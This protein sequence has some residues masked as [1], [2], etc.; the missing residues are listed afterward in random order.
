MPKRILSES[1]RHRTEYLR[2][3]HDE[4]GQVAVR[5]TY[6]DDEALEKNKRARLEGKVKTGNRF[7][8]HEGAE[9]IYAFSIPSSKAWVDFQAS[10]PGIVQRLRS[11]DQIIREKAAATLRQL[12]PEWVVAAPGHHHF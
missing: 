3:E 10:H 9:L 5:R 12:K 8:L 6:F 2:D 7:D 11:N 1:R 4:S